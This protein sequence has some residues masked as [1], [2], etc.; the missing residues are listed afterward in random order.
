MAQKASVLWLRRERTTSYRLASMQ[1]QLSSPQRK[2]RKV[3]G[4]LGPPV[5][6]LLGVRRGCGGR[7]AEGLCILCTELL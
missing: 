6:G 5:W 2:E 3:V 7:N 1:A 4:S